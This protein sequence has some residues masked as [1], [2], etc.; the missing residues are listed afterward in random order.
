MSKWRKE[1][2]NNG[3]QL[4]SNRQIWKKKKLH[5][6]NLYVIIKE[7]NTF[8]S[9][10]RKNTIFS[11]VSNSLF[12]SSS[13]RGSEDALQKTLNLNLVSVVYVKTS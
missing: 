13:D 12:I 11:M 10:T 6:Y 9:L 1:T 4:A 5:K 7:Y 2:W 3:K 8:V